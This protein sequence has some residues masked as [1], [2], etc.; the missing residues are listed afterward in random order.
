VAMQMAPAL[1]LLLPRKQASP[2]FLVAGAAG[3][4]WYC[5]MHIVVLN[6]L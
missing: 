6:T 4:S 3:N 5:G 1:L 2:H